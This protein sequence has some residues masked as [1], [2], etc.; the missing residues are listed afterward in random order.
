VISFKTRHSRRRQRAQLVH[1]DCHQRRKRYRTPANEQRKHA[2]PRRHE[3][4]I[5]GA[6]LAAKVRGSRPRPLADSVAS[7]APTRS[8]RERPPCASIA[9]SINACN[10]IRPFV[11]AGSAIET[12]LPATAL[13]PQPPNLTPPGDPHCR[14]AIVDAT[15]SRYL[16]PQKADSC[17]RAS[18]RSFRL[19]DFA[20]HTPGACP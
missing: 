16:Q 3:Q 4:T 17:F 1:V 13:P 8:Q 5:E 7:M 10:A 20:A 11:C 9:A 2:P 14:P 12:R 6:V 18:R 19:R 15:L